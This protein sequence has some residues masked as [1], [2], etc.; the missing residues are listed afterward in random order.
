MVLKFLSPVG[1]ACLRGKAWFLE[2]SQRHT[3]NKIFS[4]FR[5]KQKSRD[6][7]NFCEG[8]APSTAAIA[9]T[10]QGCREWFIITDARERRRAE[11]VKCK[12]PWRIHSHQQRM[13]SPKSTLC[14]CEDRDGDARVKPGGQSPV[15]GMS[16]TFPFSVGYLQN[17]TP[18]TAT[19]CLSQHYLLEE[20][21]LLWIYSSPDGEAF[22]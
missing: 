14:E 4:H 5:S 16:E 22:T 2:D 19:P 7:G 18:M 21:N 17:E 15:P 1:K 9:G 10:A 20:D 8:L 13:S 6:P 11:K 3:A 12:M